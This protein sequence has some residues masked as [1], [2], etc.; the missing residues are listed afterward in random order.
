MVYDIG[1][2][3]A[4]GRV[5]NGGFVDALRWQAGDKLEFVLTQ[6]AIVIRVASEGLFDVPQ[7]HR[8]VIPAT[9]RKRYAIR[10]GDQVLLAAAPDY[11]VAIVYPS[12]VLDEMITRYHSAYSATGLDEHE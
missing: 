9:A 11:G 6:G 2:V 4:S 10:A 3:D 1:R 7:R 8:I 5:A 12:S